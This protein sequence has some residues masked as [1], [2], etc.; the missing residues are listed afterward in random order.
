MYEIKETC[1]GNKYCTGVSEIKTCAEPV[2]TGAVKDVY[3]CAS[4]L[5]SVEKYEKSSNPLKGEWKTD[6]T[7]KANQVCM[8]KK[9]GV[10]QTLNASCETKVCDE[11]AVGCQTETTIGMCVNN[12]WTTVGVCGNN[13]KCQDGKCVSTIK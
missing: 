7:C 11:L 6:K 2:L 10:L 8:M 3:R 13:G 9:E 1:S 4:D 5:K 12:A